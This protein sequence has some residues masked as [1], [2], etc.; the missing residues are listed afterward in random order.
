L[1]TG[2]ILIVA[3]KGHENVQDYGNSKNFA[4]DK[5]CILKNI[6]QKNKHLSKDLKLNIL[7]EESQKNHFPLKIKLRQAS[8]NSKKI[9]N[10]DIVFA[11]KGKKKDGN[12][13]VSESFKKG[14][15]LAVVNRIYRSKIR[16][17]QLFEDSLKY[18]LKILNYP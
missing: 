18:L 9:K 8:I 14:A 5:K 4:S 6:K 1:L 12:F 10:N 2:E 7:K 15:S 11:I 17:K 3:G 13:F 16:S